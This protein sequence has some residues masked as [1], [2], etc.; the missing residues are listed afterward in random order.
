MGETNATQH[1][2][3]QTSASVASSKGAA[4]STSGETFT[5]EQVEKQVSDALAKA[6]RDAKK[7]EATRAEIAKQ[8]E[9]L[10]NWQAQR[11]AEVEAKELAELE[12]V[13]K[14]KPHELPTLL[15]YKQKLA[16]QQKA[17]REREQALAKQEAENAERLAKATAYEFKETASTIAA[18]YQVDLDK[19]LETGLTDVVALDKVA[20]LMPKKDAAAFKPDS[21]KSTTGSPGT[22]NLTPRELI[23]RG[24]AK[25]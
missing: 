3:A 21:G 22:Q 15:A 25:K 14:E 23:A 11:E 1:D 13:T 17:V 16:A 2:T 12:G 5:R 4:G 20:A 18:K 8:Q 7:L 10:K 19:L 24:L 6:G 9:D